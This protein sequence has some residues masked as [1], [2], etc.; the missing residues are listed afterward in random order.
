MVTAL[1]L[2]AASYIGMLFF[3]RVFG[4]EDFKTRDNEGNLDR[5]Q[6]YTTVAVIFVL[7]PLVAPF[8][9]GYGALFGIGKLICK[10]VAE[11]EDEYPRSTDSV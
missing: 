3:F 10:F 7:S 6:T 5:H 8:G 1:S 4:V 11:D 2:I 9:L